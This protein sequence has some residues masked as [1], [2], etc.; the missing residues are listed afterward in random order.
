MDCLDKRSNLTGLLLVVAKE[1]SK[2]K[3]YSVDTGRS[4]ET[5]LAL[6]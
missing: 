1:L 3:L 2:C 6:N 4:G 5:D